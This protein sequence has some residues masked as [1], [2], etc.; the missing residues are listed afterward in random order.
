[1]IR[2]LEVGYF[3]FDVLCPEVLF[4]LTVV[5][6]DVCRLEIL[7]V[8]DV[9]ENTAEGGE[10]IGVVCK[11]GSASCV[12]DVP[13]VHDGIGYFFPTVP[14]VAVVVVWL[15]P[16]GLVY[17]RLA[18]PGAMAARDFLILLISSVLLLLLLLMLVASGGTACLRYDCCGSP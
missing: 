14:A 7:W 1:M 13:C 18:T 4:L 15:R 17:W 10:M 11:L 5:L 3:E 2:G 12:D 6:L 9:V 16:R 8:L